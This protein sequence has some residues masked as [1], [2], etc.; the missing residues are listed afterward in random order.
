MKIPNAED[1]VVPPAK[2]VDYLLSETHPDGKHKAKFFYAFGFSLDDWQALEQ[3]L[4]QHIVEYQVAK[5]ELSR[6][7]TRYVVEGI[8][9]APDGRSPLS[10]TVWF[11]KNEEVTPHFVSAYPLQRRDDD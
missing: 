8:I 10:R 11:I 9:Q 7:G 3:T 5:I 6:F 4:R 1:A 2:I